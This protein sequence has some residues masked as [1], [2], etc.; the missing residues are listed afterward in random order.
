MCGLVAL[1]A[2][3]VLAPASAALQAVQALAGLAVLFFAPGALFVLSFLRRAQVRLFDL[4]CLSFAANCVL[5][6]GAT[7]LIKA[8]GC[9]LTSA[10]FVGA[11]LA[12]TAL[13]AGWLMTRRQV[14]HIVGDFAG[15]GWLVGLSGLALVGFLLLTTRPFLPG[16]DA[17]WTLDTL[18]RIENAEFRPA[19][20]REDGITERRDDAWQ[21]LGRQRFR[22]SAGTADLAFEN[23][24]N[25]AAWTDLWLLIE[26]H[27]EGEIQLRK[28]DELLESLYAHPRFQMGQHPRNYPPPNFVVH[29]IVALPPGRTTVTL[30]Y[31]TEPSAQ[32]DAFLI[33]TDLSNLDRAAF[34]TAFRSRCLVDNIG[35]RQEALELAR[36]LN[37]R[38]FLFTHSYDGTF[39]DRGGYTLVNFPLPFFI[40]SFAL[41]SMGDRMTSV[42]LAYLVIFLGIFVAT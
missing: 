6:I 38:L 30:A 15:R 2:A 4:L 1:H 23:P 7:T 24:T 26:A 14:P 8:M 10:H 35:D 31:T 28:G 12:L 22:L 18:P 29:R 34:L 11:V 40:H 5:F 3:S 13:G 32:P 37:S 25:V 42:H 36:M 33:V 21:S 16:E 17:Y 20:L 39:F 41:L 19:N 9:V 27:G